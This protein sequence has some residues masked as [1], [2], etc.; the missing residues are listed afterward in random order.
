MSPQIQLLA[1]G[2]AAG[3]PRVAD[4]LTLLSSQTVPFTAM[5]NGTNR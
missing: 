3:S 4:D 1:A 2:V 5:K